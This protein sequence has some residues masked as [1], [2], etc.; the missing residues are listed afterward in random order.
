MADTRDRLAV[1]GCVGRVWG[2]GVCVWGPKCVADESVCVC[3]V[4]LSYTVGAAA[5]LI[6]CDG[7]HACVYN[8]SRNR[9]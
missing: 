6:S 5:V 2:E 3:W 8:I 1:A 7:F 4:V 9:G